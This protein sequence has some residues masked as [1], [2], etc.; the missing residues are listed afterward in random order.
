MHKFFS[1][2]TVKNITL[3][4]FFICLGGGL[5]LFLGQDVCFDLQNYHLYIPYAFLHGRMGTDIIPAGALHTFFNPLLDVPSFLLFSYLN[6]WP[7]V[8]GF[9]MGGLYG[10][11]LFVLW[12]TLGFFFGGDTREEKWLR[13][14]VLCLAGTGIASLSQI[15]RFTNEMQTAVIGMIACWFLCKSAFEEHSG[16]KYAFAAVFA[17]SLAAGMKYTVGP[18]AVGICFT[19][20]V[21][22]WQEKRTWK[23]YVGLAVFAAFGF[24][25]TDGWFLWKKWTVLGNPLFPYFNHIFK[26]PYFPVLSLPNGFATP[27]GLKEY[28][29]LPFLRF[30][31]PVLEYRL[32]FRLVLG[33]VSFWGLFLFHLIRRKA[34]WTKAETLCLCLFAGSY[35]PWVLLFGNM[36]YVICLEAFSSVLF[37]LFIRRFISVRAAMITILLIWG[38]LMRP[39]T[40]LDLAS[41]FLRQPFPDK[42]ISF[43]APVSIPD[44]AF[45]VVAGHISFLIPF[46][47]PNARYAGG[48][49]LRP[50]KIPL[51]PPEELAKFNW[52]QPNDY[53]HYFAE[54]ARNAIA[55]HQG[56]VYILA[57]ATRW[58]WED[59]LW[60][61]YG[62]KV[63]H[64]GRKCRFFH[65]S[66]DVI[67][68]GFVVCKAEKV[69][70]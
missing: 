24:L 17:A 7:L 43:S 1:C 33:M 31:F 52:L 4:L 64:S 23:A 3:F 61:E 15:G 55:Q 22:F 41:T 53:K 70:D 16:V 66:L 18:V 58:M 29:L 40:S 19:A 67:Y 36:R 59:S 2:F 5:S 38:V 21:L 10:L 32:D 26:S 44:G 13:V 57:P 51:A 69:G 30:N 42:N 47:N 48:V 35:I 6:N 11:F 65:V 20:L 56:P 68:D 63:P 27:R 28:L 50:D 45:V 39:S 60:A 34:V 54:S 62:V 25:L 37:I 46:L 14:A 12:K 9:V 49:Y 8:T